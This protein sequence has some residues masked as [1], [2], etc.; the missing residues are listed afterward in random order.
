VYERVVILAAGLATLAGHAASILGRE[1]GGILLGYPLDD[2][3]LRISRQAHQDHG[4]RTVHV[5]I[6][7]S[8][9]IVRVALRDK[10]QSGATPQTGQDYTDPCALRIIMIRFVRHAR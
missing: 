1:T 9:A 3:T 2:T 5:S 7:R 6:C 8:A 4:L 10:R